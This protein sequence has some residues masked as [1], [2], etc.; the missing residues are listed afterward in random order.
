[1]ASRVSSKSDIAGELRAIARR[2]RQV[3]ALV[4]DKYPDEP[5]F[6]QSIEDYVTAFSS[7]ALVVE[8]L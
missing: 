6:A 1:M 8:R 2:I 4:R 7:A 5:R 3:A